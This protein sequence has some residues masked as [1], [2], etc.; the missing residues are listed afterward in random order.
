MIINLKNS[1]LF[2]LILI[3]VVIIFYNNR[4]IYYTPGAVAPDTPMQGHIKN[5]QPFLHKGHT[6][7]PLAT[8][9]CNAL[10]LSSKR[11][12]VGKESKISPVD[13]ALGW[14]PMSSGKVVNQIKVSQSWRW[15]RWRVKKYPIPKRE[16]IQNSANMHIIPADNKVEKIVKSIKKGDIVTFSGFL[17]EVVAPNARWRWKSSLTRNDSGNFSCELVFVKD[18]NIVQK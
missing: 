18:I 6:I 9:K 10:V 2:I 14:G 17:V 16:I 5:P 1:I 4:P 12:R 15:Y 8:F 7:K 3:I 13:L 11:Y